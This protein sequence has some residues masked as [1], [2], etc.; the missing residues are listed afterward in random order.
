MTLLVAADEFLRHGERGAAWERLPRGAVW[1]LTLTAGATYGAVMASFGGVA[2]G[3]VWM[4]VYGAVKVPM[5]FVTT[6]LVAVPC[7]YVANVLSGLGSDFRVVWR[8]LVDFQLAVALQLAAL[9]PAIAFV[10]LTTTDYRVAQACSTLLFAGVAFNARVGFDRA[11]APLVARA[12]AHRRLR[13]L[14]L[15]LYA[16]VG[17]QMGWDLRPFVGNPDLPVQFF[18][19]E[20][21]NA[22]LEVG[23]VL[24]EAVG[25]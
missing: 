2:D 19:E 21:G 25:G 9:A 6:L 15:G 16:F 18:R 1:A 23:R 22:Y 10:N 3:R 20:I 12:P 17:V 5:L 8:A 4:V 13:Q 14:W 24:W 7:F 11:Y